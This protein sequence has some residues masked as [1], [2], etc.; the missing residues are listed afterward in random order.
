MRAKK[1]GCAASTF[2]SDNGELKNF[3]LV[4]N[5]SFAN[6]L[7]QPIYTT[8]RTAS[9]CKSGRS[10]TYKGLCTSSENI[11]PVAFNY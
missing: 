10:S 6:M 8:G 9:K 5:Y 2:L 3:Y 1:I 7:T 4:C 11:A